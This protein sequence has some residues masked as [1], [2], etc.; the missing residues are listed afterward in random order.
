MMILGGLPGRFGTAVG[1]AAILGISAVG[2]TTAPT[3]GQ[4]SSPSTASASTSAGYPSSKAVDR[5]VDEL[6]KHPAPPS[7]KDGQVGLYLIDAAG[8]P[9]V[10]IANEPDEGLNQC[11]SPVWSHDGRRIAFDATRGTPGKA[12]FSSSRIRTLELDG[13]RLAGQDL[14]LGNCPDFSP[15]DDRLVFLLNNAPNNQMGVWLMKADGSG[16]RML[17]DYGRPRWSPR[18]TQFLI[19]SFGTPTEVTIMDV[20]PENS[21]K[22]VLPDHQVFSVPSWAGDGTVVAAVGPFKGPADSIALIDAT[23]PADGKIRNVLWKKGDGLEVQPES[24][25]Y[26]PVTGRCV[27]LGKTQDRGRAL[28]TIDPGQGKPGKARRLEPGDTFDNLI[29]DPTFSPDGRYV[30]FSCDRKPPADAKSAPEKAA[31]ATKP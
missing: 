9:A 16:R 4:S 25:I 8:G 2:Q 20:R 1:L 23:S 12:E 27:F 13:D 10:R 14:G 17:G 28:Y 6:R 15:T 18:S 29:Q 31:G 21:G 19:A 7:R 26:S 3:P 22:L 24:P 11:G 5:L 30:V